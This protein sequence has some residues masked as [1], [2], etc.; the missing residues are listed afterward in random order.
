MSAPLT[1]FLGVREA[2]SRLTGS[3]ADYAPLLEMAK[4]KRYVLLG[5]ATHGTREFYQSRADITR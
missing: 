4:G 2:A 5:E 3:A 1:P